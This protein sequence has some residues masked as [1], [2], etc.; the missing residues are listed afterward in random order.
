MRLRFY[1][2]PYAKGFGENFRATLG[3]SGPVGMP[4]G[5]HTPKQKPLAYI[6]HVAFHSFFHGHVHLFLPSVPGWVHFVG[7][8]LHARDMNREAKNNEQHVRAIRFGPT[9]FRTKLECAAVVVGSYISRALLRPCASE[10]IRDLGQPPIQK[11]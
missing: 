6:F 4:L 11:P 2:N 7:V 10:F 9:Y 1:C 8:G 5:L 3:K